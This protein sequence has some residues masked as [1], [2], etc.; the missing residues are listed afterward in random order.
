MMSQSNCLVF[1]VTT[2]QA[3]GTW[4]FNGGRKLTVFE[5][6]KIPLSLNVLSYNLH[7]MYFKSLTANLGLKKRDIQGFDHSS[8]LKTL[9]D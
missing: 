4:R 2:N 7:T 3:A 9:G 5:R 1:L 6:K 8:T